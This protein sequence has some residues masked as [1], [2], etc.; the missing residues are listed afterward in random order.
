[1]TYFSHKTAIS[2]AISIIS[3]QQAMASGYHFGTQSVTAQS[4]ANASSA[5]AGDASTIFANP[6]GLALLDGHQITAA[7]N[8]VLPNIEYHDAQ[9]EY[10]TGQPIPSQGNSTSG[11]I[12]KD[13]VVAPHLYGAYKLN[14]KVTLGLGIYIPFASS[15]EYQHNSVLRY[16]MNQLGLTSIAIEPVIAI[17]AT[18]KHSFGIGFI[19]QHSEAE[20]RKYADWGTAIMLQQAQPTVTSG[21]ADGYATLKGSDWGFGYHLGWLYDI[22]DQFRIG[23]SY[24]SKVEHN[25][26]GTANWETDSVIASSLRSTLAGLGYVASEGVSVKIVTPESLSLHSRYRA[27][28]KL[29][30]FG[31]ITW[32]RHS[33]FNKAVLQFENKKTVSSTQPSTTTIQ[34]NWRDTYKI[35]LGASYQ[36]NEPLQ[37]RAG[38]AFDKSPVRNASYRLSTLPDGNRIWFSAGIRY[39][40]KQKHIFDV[41]YSHIHINDTEIQNAAATGSDVDSKGKSS[42]K[43]KNYADIIGLQYTYQF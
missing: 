38:I 4:T 6:A 11:K 40:V 17:K 5:E 18:E 21:Q 14:D 28:D 1:M 22:N 8:F 24:R 39:T 19:A 27:T 12:T 35:A 34:P 25:L 31:D 9:A 37:L 13:V 23:I 20:L 2:L 29:N 41:A 10:I 26:K 42:A 7:L 16:N 33:R 15:T 43:F 3:I 36:I 30:L 32:T